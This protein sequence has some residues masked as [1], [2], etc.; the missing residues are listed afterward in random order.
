MQGYYFCKPC[1]EEEFLGWIANKAHGYQT[2]HNG[3]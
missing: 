2:V 3:R 1:P